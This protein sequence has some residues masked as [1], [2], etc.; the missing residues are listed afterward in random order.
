MDSHYDINFDKETLMQ[1]ARDLL[2]LS[3]AKLGDNLNVQ[4]DTDEGVCELTFH[5]T[6]KN[7]LH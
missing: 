6:T 5:L 1:L 2:A 7:T 4:F 3:K